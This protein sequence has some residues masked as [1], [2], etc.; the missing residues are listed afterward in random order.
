VQF[1][2]LPVTEGQ[3]HPARRARAQLFERRASGV[4][5]LL[6]TAELPLD[7][8]LALAAAA[9]LEAA[10]AGFEA[11]APGPAPAAVAAPD[12]ADAPPE[13][14]RDGAGA[15]PGSAAEAAPEP[16]A[17]PAGLGP[18]ASA[19]PDSVLAAPELGPDAAS[20]GAAP[21]AP[22]APA[23]LVAWQA[24]RQ[25]PGPAGPGSTP[26]AESGLA[27]YGPGA[28]A[29]AGRAADAQPDPEG[30]AAA[31][32]EAGGAGCGGQPGASAQLPPDPRAES[33]QGGPPGAAAGAP[34]DGARM[35]VSAAALPGGVDAAAAPG[36]GG[37]AGGGAAP[38]PAPAAARRTLLLPLVHAG[39][40]GGGALWRGARLRVCVGYSAVALGAG[41]DGARAAALAAN[42]AGACEV[43]SD[44]GDGSDWHRSDE[45]GSEGASLG[46][47]DGGRPAQPGARAC[48]AAA[49]VRRRAIFRERQGKAGCGGRTVFC[50]LVCKEAL[51]ASCHVRG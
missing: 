18:A 5:V 45:S 46:D 35:A 32:E 29:E 7:E 23:K 8:L 4:E 11:A 27:E 38:T 12:A 30:L 50:Q 6:A 51:V 20:A 34:P 26:A 3:R 44:G 16:A 42:G 24:Q 14:D 21:G 48:T 9:G 39:A 49:P 41:A 28:L 2:L 36:Q 37:A 17:A 22:P 43:P 13:P 1:F 25:Q 15:K 19:D 33:A 40:G 10:A 47:T 31:L